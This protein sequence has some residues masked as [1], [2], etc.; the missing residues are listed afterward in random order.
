MS[1]HLS[2]HCFYSF[3]P[4]SLSISLS[5]SLSLSFTLSLFFCFSFRFMKREKLSWSRDHC[6]LNVNVSR[7]QSGT[8]L[9]TRSDICTCNIR[10]YLYY[11]YYCCCCCCCCYIKENLYNISDVVIVICNC[12]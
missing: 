1:L 2:I 8:R 10:S 12:N 6:L 3:L 7:H 4:P 5:F 9:F 11:Y